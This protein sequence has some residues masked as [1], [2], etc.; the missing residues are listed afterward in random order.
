MHGKEQ[1]VSA[2]LGDAR[3]VTVSG[4]GVGTTQELGGHRTGLRRLLPGAGVGSV[5]H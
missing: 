2:L 1:P 5:N 3:R 4:G